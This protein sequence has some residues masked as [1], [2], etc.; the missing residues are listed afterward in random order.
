M[1][2]Q[3]EFDEQQYRGKLNRRFVSGIL[4]GCFVALFISAA[5]CM[6]YLLTLTPTTVQSTNSVNSV[7]NEETLTK[8]NKI[9]SVIDSNFY[10]TD[11]SNEAK[12]N[13]LYKGLMDS[14]DDPYS[15]YYTEEELTDLMND[16]AGIYYGIG[17]YV[18]MD[19]TTALPRIS[20]VIEGTPAE[21]AKLQTDDIIYEVDKE[22]TQGLELSEVVSLIKGE[23]GTTVHLTLLR[24]S[25]LEEIEV[26]VM[27]AQV[28]V[29][30]VKTQVMD[31]GV[32]YLQ[33][34]EFDEV[35]PDQFTEGMAELRAADIKGLIIDLRSNPGGSLTAVCDI[36][37][38]L[39]PKGTIVYTVDRD[40]N[41]E[42]YTCDGTHE[43][44]IPVVVL[45]NKYSASASEILS[46]AIKDYGIGT[47]V[48]TTTY[49]KGIVQRIFDLKDGTAIK[50]TVSN[51]YT[52]NGNDIHGV[53]IDPDVEVE[54]DADAYAE[55]KTDNQLNK[56]V[57]V[58]KEAIEDLEEKAG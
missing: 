29:P 56:A 12:A 34:T 55:D 44:D 21:E 20:G 40:G 42:D 51:Y 28:S 24:G 25:D 57:E 30:T 13:G 4:V 23:E 54:F 11:V 27:R 16:T 37:R 9:E 50:L 14:L 6:A 3:T 52:P 41:R 32:G 46:G 5:V 48:G 17:A 7:L 26:D 45:V 31:D 47:L 58:L 1:D 22:T 53:G 19:Q 43:I 39:L 2:Y 49:G 10:K 38:Q 33:I 15:V 36:A 35:T 8:I 18:S